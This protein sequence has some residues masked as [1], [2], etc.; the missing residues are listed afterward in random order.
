MGCCMSVKRQRELEEEEMRRQG[1]RQGWKKIFLVW[2]DKNNSEDC[3]IFFEIHTA[4]DNKS[5]SNPERSLGG[6]REVG[7][8]QRQNQEVEKN[9]EK[10]RIK[11]G[12][13][14]GH[15]KSISAGYFLVK[16]LFQKEKRIVW[17]ESKS[18]I[19]TKEYIKRKYSSK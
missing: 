6:R 15:L 11:P 1:R 10:V 4:V 14:C 18:P 7:E 17:D 8:S 9:K 13:I 5:F 16:F 2:R 19:V 3:I 12:S